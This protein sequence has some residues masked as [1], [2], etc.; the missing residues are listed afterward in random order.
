MASRKNLNLQKGKTNVQNSAKD[1]KIRLREL[2]AHRLIEIVERFLSGLSKR[3]QLEF[4]NLLPSI[5]VQ[6]LEALLPYANDDDFLEIVEEFCDRVREGSFVD[7]AGYDPDEGEYR[8][9]GDDSWSD[10]M[11]E[12]FEYTER[13]FL[14]RRYR[15][16]EKAYE[17]LF[18]CIE[19]EVNEGGYYFTTS[20][21]QG[22]LSTDLNKAR[23]NYFQSLCHIY[24]GEELADK[25]I[26]G[27]RDY[28]DIGSN[29]PNLKGLFAGEEKII[30]WLERA[31]LAIPS[32]DNPET[33]LSS[34]DLP[35]EFLRQ[36][37]RDFKSPGELERFV[38]EY[39]ESH[40]WA[41][42]D[43]VRLFVGE[44]NWEKVLF[45]ANKG[46]VGESSKKRERNAI[47]ADY[48]ARSAEQLGKPQ[49]VSALWEA[50]EHA[51]SAQRYVNLRQKAIGKK[52]QE[53]YP[54]IVQRL[55]HDLSGPVS[56]RQLQENRLLVEVL[57][58]EGEYEKALALT[59]KRRFVS[60]DDDSEDAS[61]AAVIFLLY[62]VVGEKG[63]YREQYPE[64][65]KRLNKS[66]EF[67]RLSGRELFKNA[68]SPE[69]RDRQ[70][71]WIKDLI[72]PRIDYVL[73][74]KM[75]YLYREAACEAKLIEELHRF[76]GRDDLARGFIE[77][78]Y[79]QYRYH[80]NFKAELRKLRLTIS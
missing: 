33:G 62:S 25:I 10:E 8:G 20:D 76:Q 14:A 39:G 41:Y 5:E 73:R 71:N 15:A 48:K 38:E 23:T 80:R 29:Q 55:T 28:R 11:D 52:W 19:L 54:K 49:S 32:R 66:S 40:P 53:Y 64:I 2:P 26:D 37:Y 31:L 60:F 27:I 35:A 9:F 36:I 72:R 43:I 24:T 45:W 75:Q 3:Q 59:G 1:L 17:L 4:L 30:G 50:F 57:L 46:L 12:L 79:A 16:A 6:D 56:G 51:P 42:E 78:L 47:L 22:A 67:I 69:G 21:P 68:P 65:A 13:Y 7:G 58:A 34:L 44:E 18:E 77:G 74:N 61:N 70:I 63:D